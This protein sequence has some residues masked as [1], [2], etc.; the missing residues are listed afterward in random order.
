MIAR[1]TEL[2]RDRRP[3]LRVIDGD[4]ARALDDRAEVVAEI[5]SDGTVR[6]RAPDDVGAHDHGFATGHV[7]G[8][9]WTIW[10]D[11]RYWSS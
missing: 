1:P 5:L 2:T 7:A 4:G 6:M 3:A 10:W 11:R 9:G 8:D